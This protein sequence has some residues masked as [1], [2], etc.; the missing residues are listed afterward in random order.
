VITPV[1][2]LI[3]IFG[4]GASAVWLGEPL[5]AW[6]LAAAA[7]VISGLAA[8]VLYPMWQSRRVGPG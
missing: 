8:G 6:K 2:L 5:P 3:P 4:L 1:A 7:L